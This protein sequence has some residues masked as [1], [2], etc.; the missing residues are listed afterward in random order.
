MI[1]LKTADKLRTW[2]SKLTGSLGLVPTMGSLHAGHLALV[3]LALRGCDHVI[4]TIFVN[5]TQFNEP[6]DYDRYP[7]DHNRD[8]NLLRAL[9]VGAIFMP[10][11]EDIYPGGDATTVTVA[12][13][14]SLWEGAHRPSHFDGVATVVTKLLNLIT[15]DRAYF[16]EKDFQQLRIVQ[17]LVTDL[18]LAV[19]IV[20]CPIVRAN[21]GVALSSRNTLLDEQS[22]TKA[23]SLI[24]SLQQVRNTIATGL[25]VDTAITAALA[26]LDA[27]GWDVDYLALINGTT[28][29]P[30]SAVEAGARLIIA[31]TI[32]G[33]RLIDNIAAD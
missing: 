13:C 22:R 32:G 29:A 25:S 16:G 7:R 24:H 30:I 15:A 3:E 28:L 1:I 20:P 27:D 21:D 26:K 6:A 9:G 8:I 19:E 10:G 11:V 14:A 18:H 12:G 2:Q 23:P 4:V 33:V 17:R 31:A 5:P